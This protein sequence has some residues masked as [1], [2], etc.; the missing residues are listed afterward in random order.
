[1]VFS[2]AALDVGDQSVI[3]AADGGREAEED[4]ADGGGQWLEMKSKGFSGLPSSFSTWRTP[5]FDSPDYTPGIR[6]G[7]TR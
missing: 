2:V 1:M 7:K 3:G 6:L 4:D 5:P